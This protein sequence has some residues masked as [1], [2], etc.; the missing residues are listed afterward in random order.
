MSHRSN[1]PQYFP[2]VV[3]SLVYGIYSVLFY[4]SVQLLL[5]RR[6]S[7]YK[8]HLGWLTTLFL[9]STIHI[10]LAYAWAFITDTGDN[11]IYELFSLKNPRPVLY[12][13]E[14][15][16]SVHSI[17]ILLKLR[18]SLANAIADFIIIHRCYVIWGYRWRAVALLAV[19]YVFT[20]IGAILGMLPLSGTS[21]RAAMAICIVSVF[22][23]NVLGAGLAAGRIW[24]ISRT[25]AN[26]LG[27]RSRRRY[28]DLTAIIIESGLMYPTGLA[29]VVIV[30]LIPTTPTVS[31]SIC[32]AACYHIVGIA[33]TL[34]I[35][36]VGMGVSTDDVDT[37]V[38]IT[39]TGAGGGLQLSDF[40][41]P[42][43]HNTTMQLE[44]RGTREDF[45]GRD[46][47]FLV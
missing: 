13:P 24:W 15:P 41:A 37:C 45:K 46:N 3:D 9:L 22:L 8:L 18:Y 6:T 31:V 23:T 20:C 28:L 4:H 43:G 21:E 25:A 39:R 29:L 26:Y 19:A 44:V 2:L 27:R 14:D 16:I 1:F 32:L 42:W 30:Y 40:D 11:A 47:Q 35:V 12:L 7:N 36:R 38:T 10:A 33:P 34:L 5:S 17:G